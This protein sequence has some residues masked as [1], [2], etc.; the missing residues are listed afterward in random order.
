[1]KKAFRRRSGT[2]NRIDNDSSN[3]R[4]SRY[5]RS[6]LSPMSAAYG[7]AYEARERM[8]ERGK[9]CAVEPKYVTPAEAYDTFMQKPSKDAE[10]ARERMIARYNKTNDDLSRSRAK[11]TPGLNQDSLLAAVR[12]DVQNVIRKKALLRNY[13][14]K[15]KSGASAAR[16]RMID[17]MK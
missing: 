5:R 3:S 10:E 17:R 1:M 9:S 15:K 7:H 16:V 4:G 14:A 11:R 12:K 13:A 6:K 8:I 2:A